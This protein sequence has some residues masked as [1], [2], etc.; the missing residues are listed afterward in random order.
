MGLHSFRFRGFPSWEF[1]LGP[2]GVRAPHDHYGFEWSNRKEPRPLITNQRQCFTLQA[3]SR[4]S[5]PERLLHSIYIVSIYTAILK[6]C[7]LST[8]LKGITAVSYP[9]IEP[10]TF[11]LEAQFLTYCATLRP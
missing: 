9:G 8:L 7:R 2:C 1:P 11:R 3:F 4:R 6:Q 10:M 5:Y